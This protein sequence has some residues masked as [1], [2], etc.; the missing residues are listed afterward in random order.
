MSRQILPKPL[1]LTGLEPQALYRLTLL[2]PEDKAPQSRGLT[3][4]KTGSLTL[5]GQTLM[6]KG[7]L[8]PIA[9]PATLWVIEGTR[10]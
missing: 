6:T 5:S 7:L 8:L 1:R 9:W 10:L 2:N 4:L 3:A